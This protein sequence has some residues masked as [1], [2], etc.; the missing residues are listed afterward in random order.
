MRI[1]QRMLLAVLAPLAI[2]SGERYD[3]HRQGVVGHL[4]LDHGKDLG[5]PRQQL[6]KKRQPPPP[7]R[8]SRVQRAA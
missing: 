4:A 5:T 8:K 6:W 1:S 7:L 3:P 2:A